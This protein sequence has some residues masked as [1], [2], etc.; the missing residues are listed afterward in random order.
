[1]SG[2]KNSQTLASI[3]HENSFEAI[4]VVR[5]HRNENYHISKLFN[6]LNEVFGNNMGEYERAKP[7]KAGQHYKVRP[8]FFSLNAIV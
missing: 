5:Y 6:S 7:K 3:I 4:A 1:V 8:T 2:D